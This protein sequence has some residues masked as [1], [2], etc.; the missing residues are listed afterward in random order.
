V[1]T[2]TEV[3]RESQKK[4]YKCW[5]DALVALEVPHFHF[6]GSPGAYR[7]RSIAMRV[8]SCVLSVK[9]TA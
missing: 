6:F 8:P 1:T 5:S 7:T 9:L 3:V 2:V 4:G